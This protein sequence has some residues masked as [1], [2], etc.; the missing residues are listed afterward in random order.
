MEKD[1]VVTFKTISL[2]DLETCDAERELKNFV[3]PLNPGVEHFICTNA[4]NAS[5]QGISQTH[6]VIM[7]GETVTKVVG[8]FALA[9]KVI[10]VHRSSVT[11][12]VFKS[13]QKFG[14]LDNATDSVTFSS[15]LIAQFGKNFKNGNDRYITGIDLLDIACAKVRE[16]HRII[17]GRAVYLECEYIP[18]LI[19]FYENTGFVAFGSRAPGEGDNGEL[20][21]M[22]RILR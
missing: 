16:A 15:P 1:T 19:E 9:N 2:L 11:K 17:G 10:T 4:L 18:K 22:I 21:Q 12:T 8:F 13:V 20:I 5:L 3:C 14:Q 7:V 6:M